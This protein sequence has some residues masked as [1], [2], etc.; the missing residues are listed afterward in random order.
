MLDFGAN[1]TDMSI[2]SEG[3]LVFSQSIAIGSDSLTQ[4]I[5][6]KFNFDNQR[7]KNL[8]EIMEL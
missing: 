7:Q 6:N 2:I 3:Y 1:S 4:A 8:R 5:V